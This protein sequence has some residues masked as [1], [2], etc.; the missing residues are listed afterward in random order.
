IQAVEAMGKKPGKDIFV[1][2]IDWSDEGI[3]AVADRKMST[4]VGGHIFEGAWSLILV[5]DYHYGIDFVNDPGVRSMTSM[6]S[7]STDNVN[8]YKKKLR[9]QD[10]SRIDFKRFSKKHNPD[11]DKYDFSLNGLLKAYR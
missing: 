1:G 6:H 10:W 5:H 4:S 8:D 7:V 9:N 11:L 3:K 2:G